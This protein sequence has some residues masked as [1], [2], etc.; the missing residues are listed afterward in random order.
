MRKTIAVTLLVLVLLAS[1]AAI[2]AAGGKS[3]K[4]ATAELYLYQKDPGTWEIVPGGAWGKMTY[5]V[6]GACFDVVFNGHGLMPECEYTLL[7]YPDP[8]PGTG[9]MSLGVGVAN[10]G[11]NV[12]IDACTPMTSSLPIATDTNF[13]TGAKIWLVP[14]MCV[15][16]MTWHCWHPEHILFENNLITWTYT[17]P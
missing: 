3:A 16:G 15:E 4:A 7:Y 17:G 6:E 5:K 13:A 10:A 9:M 2:A 1:G 11:G 12:N 14:T 8:W